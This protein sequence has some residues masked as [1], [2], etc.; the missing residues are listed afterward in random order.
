M[1]SLRVRVF[2]SRFTMYNIH[3]N[4]FNT[5][6]MNIPKYIL[7]SLIYYRRSH[8]ALFAGVA[9]AVTIIVGA[10]AVG[11]SVRKSLLRLVNEKLGEIKYVM[12]T[13]KH[14]P[15]RSLGERIS[16]N[17][18][19]KTAQVIALQGSAISDGGAKK[20]PEV[21][22]FG[23][24]KSFVDFFPNKSFSNGISPSHNSIPPGEAV[25]NRALA[26]KIGVKKGDIFIIRIPNP[27]LLPEDIALTKE[28][29]ATTSFRL[30]VMK[31]ADE[32]FPG[33]FSLKSE[34]K[35]QQNVF[36]N[37]EWLGKK[38]DRE[39]KCNLIL[40]GKGKNLKDLNNIV[41]KEWELEDIGLEFKQIIDP[42][43]RGRKVTEMTSES[44][45]IDDE[46][47]EQA[48]SISNAE[49]ILTY[50]V[51]SITNPENGKSCPYSFV[52][53]I[54]QRL[55]PVK[56][57]KEWNEK[58]LDNFPP[59]VIN[60][61]LAEDI[62]VKKGD[63]VEISYYVPGRMRQLS[64]EKTVFRISDIVLIKGW[65]SDRDLMP[66][67]PG[68]ADTE[69]CSE[70]D[71]GIPIDLKKVR[72][73]DEKYWD[74]HRGTPKAFIGLKQGQKLWKNQFGSLTSVRFQKTNSDIELRDK[75]S[76]ENFGLSFI[77]IGAKARFAANKSVDFGGLFLGLS[78]FIIF[79]A[80]ILTAMLFAL[81]IKYR[82][83]E[84]SILYS[85]GFENCV[86][87][88]ILMI[89]HAVP[90]LLGACAG[91]PL[92]MLYNSI[93]IDLLNTLWQDAVG[94]TALTP[95]I[96]PI[97]ALIGSCSGLF[98]ALIT[99]WLIIRKQLKKIRNSH[100]L[101]NRKPESSKLKQQRFHWTLCIG[102]VFSTI[103]VII[104]LSYLL[105]ET[106]VKPSAP[107]FAAGGLL[108]IASWSFS[109]NLFT[110]FQ[111]KD[112]SSFLAVGKSSFKSV[113]QVSVKNCTC[114]M[115]RSMA[116]IMLLSCGIFLTLAVAINL[117]SAKDL[118]QNS[119]GTGGYKFF[120]K[121]TLPV[122]HDLNTEKGRKAYGLDPILFKEVAFV[123]MRLSDGNEASCLNLHRVEN[124]AILG[125][126]FSK[127]AKRKAFTFKALDT[128]FDYDDPWNDLNVQKA[129]N[130]GWNAIP[131]V[132]DNDV[133]IWIMGKK[134][135]DPLEVKD[136]N[137]KQYDL[138]LAG[139]LSNS[140]FQGYVL[141][142]E[143]HFINLNPDSSGASVLL[144][145]C[146]DIQ[147]KQVENALQKALSGL[148]VE[149]ENCSDRLR[150]FQKVENTYLSIFLVLGGLGLLIG[151]AGFGIVVVRNIIERK[152][153]F[154]IMHAVGFNRKLIRKIVITEHFILILI[155]T[156]SGVIAAGISAI[157][158]VI[159]SR[160]PIPWNLVILIISGIVICGFICV[161]G[162]ALSAVAKHPVKA[163]RKE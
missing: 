153:E 136:Q 60:T 156:A 125:V 76:P 103:A 1:E 102:L 108:L 44:I 33:N 149:I 74:D 57:P 53:A 96:S 120:I 140:I 157:P 72:E 118:S 84:I 7:R 52:S 112:T 163:L 41:S 160:A 150:R 63:T 141:M 58:G 135:G 152:S 19:V 22:L 66:D 127:F 82:T 23:I 34:Q 92:G 121:T 69:N 32:D 75:L 122:L 132:A 151:A 124:P 31:I 133:I 45:F 70:W 17:E 4:S 43:S 131:V 38:I 26:R 48:V 154:A 159:S 98:I 126:D 71:P 50:F 109:K 36:V 12:V 106:Y 158:A 35:N 46:I 99:M 90:A 59:I 104:V 24:D 86:I 77:D 68:L 54:D 97:P 138:L 91:I 56:S 51:N 20:I 5:I 88:R 130:S 40:A 145:D 79:S 10:L 9:L 111:N 129:G 147:Q 25:I 142:P 28:E 13:G 155:G 123:L 105:Q 89:E 21:N 67:F 47:A 116:G 64:E 119:S 93:V 87:R 83:N 85:L 16:E 42:A 18:S 2:A 65:S 15:N 134:V 94:I 80:F 137:G 73:K 107:F 128:G 100:L 95:Y 139:G 55:Y 144:V 148:G 39:K 161:F 27:G 29:D 3:L 8:S 115:M 117:K 81:S 78:F 101:L 49:G 62:G 143:K 61:W 113:I 114:N 37:L 11:D 30:K 110:R 162:A 146:P 14:F 6:R